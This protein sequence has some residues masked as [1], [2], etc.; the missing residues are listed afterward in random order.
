MSLNNTW[1]LIEKTVYQSLNNKQTQRDV[2]RQSSLSTEVSA[3]SRTKHKYASRRLGVLINKSGGGNV[4][5]VKSTSTRGTRRRYVV[6]CVSDTYTP[7]DSNRYTANCQRLAGAPAFSG[8]PTAH[9]FLTPTSC[10]EHMEHRP[11]LY[12]H[13][14]P[15]ARYSPIRSLHRY[16]N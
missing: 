14:T 9:A 7:H 12:R 5:V 1:I 6:M 4:S 10:T 2:S 16:D 11:P 15:L 3:L 13:C 8:R